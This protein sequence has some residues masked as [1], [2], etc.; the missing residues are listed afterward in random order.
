MHIPA[1]IAD[2]LNLR[3]FT[4]A[5]NSQLV[6]SGIR[7]AVEVVILLDCKRKDCF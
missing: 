7:I 6:V 4:V 1:A 2:L 3:S 5:E